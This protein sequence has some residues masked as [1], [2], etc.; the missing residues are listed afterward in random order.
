MAEDHAEPEDWEDDIELE[1]MKELRSSLAHLRRLSTIIVQ[2]PGAQLVVFR[3]LRGLDVPLRRLI[4]TPVDMNRH[5]IF[6]QQFP[7]LEEIHLYGDGSSIEYSRLPSLRILSCR[8]CILT[9]ARTG[10]TPCRTLTHLS[11]AE[12]T[13]EDIDKIVDVLGSQL[14]SLRLEQMVWDEQGRLYPTNG[15][16]W[17]KCSRLKCLHVRHQNWR[18]DMTRYLHDDP[19]DARNLPPALQTLVWSPA[20][21]R[22]F[23]YHIYPDEQKRADIRRFAEAVLRGSRTLRTVT[24]EWAGRGFYKCYLTPMKQYKEGEASEMDD[25]DWTRA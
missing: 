23:T 21:T 6:I 7:E 19:I 18:H 11:V 25:E 15:P 14:V 10:I 5:K 20:W 1:W 13:S 16:A 17:R 12:V 8:S 22:V 24:V 9:G 4:G 2:Q 3:L